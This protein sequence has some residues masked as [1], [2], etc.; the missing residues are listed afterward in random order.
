[1]N[2][3]ENYLWRDKT[4][5]LNLKFSKLHSAKVLLKLEFDTKDQVLFKVIIYVVTKALTLTRQA[6]R[7]PFLHFTFSSPSQ[8]FFGHCVTTYR[9]RGPSRTFLDCNTAISDFENP[10]EVGG[11]GI[12]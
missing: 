2:F 4:Q 3:N 7:N 10:K 12:K 9:L 8:C 1:M 11:F 6:S 5:L